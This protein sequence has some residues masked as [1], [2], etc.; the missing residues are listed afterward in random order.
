MGKK[1]ETRMDIGIF[2]EASKSVI[3][4]NVEVKKDNERD[5]KF[6]AAHKCSIHHRPQIEAST[7]CGCFSCLSTFPPGKIEEWTDAV[8]T[9][10]CPLCGIDAVIGD[11]SGF[12]ITKEFL[13]EMCQAWFGYLPEEGK[14]ITKPTIIFR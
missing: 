9:A 2:R 12:P 3:G 8:D 5:K 14:E 11:A 4:Q 1:T 7:L 10:L 6:R 13:S